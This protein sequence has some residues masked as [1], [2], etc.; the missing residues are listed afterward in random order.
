MGHKILQMLDLQAQCQMYCPT[1]QQQ[2]E[3]PTTQKR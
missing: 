3:Y 1:A 2:D